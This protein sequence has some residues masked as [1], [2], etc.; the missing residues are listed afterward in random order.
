M[1]VC[2]AWN[3][4]NNKTSI[5]FFPDN[6]NHYLTGLYQKA[7]KVHILSGIWQMDAHLKAI[8]IF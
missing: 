4:R 5:D 3:E 6:I 8:V 7:E 2:N 1:M